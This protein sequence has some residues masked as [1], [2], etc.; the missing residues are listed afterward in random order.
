MKPISQMTDNRV[1][2]LTTD[3]LQQAIIDEGILQGVPVPTQVFVLEPLYVAWAAKADATRAATGILRLLPTGDG[4]YTTEPVQV[5]VQPYWS[6]VENMAAYH[7]IREAGLLRFQQVVAA[8]AVSKKV[9]AKRDAYLAA[10]NGDAVLAQ[11][12][13]AVENPNIPWPV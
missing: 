4:N 7:A 3:E 9:I 11:K 12:F 13:W 10:A 8:A 2:Q 1:S 5:S 6:E